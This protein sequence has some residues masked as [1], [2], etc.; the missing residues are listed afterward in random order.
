MTSFQSKVVPEVRRMGYA[1]IDRPMGNLIV[2]LHE[3]DGF[4]R[5]FEVW[6]PIE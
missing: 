2:R 3:G 1:I 6:V 5:Y 4:T